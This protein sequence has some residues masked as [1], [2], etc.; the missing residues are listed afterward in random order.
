L[1]AFFC[2][3]SKNGR[4]ILEFFLVETT[5]DPLLSCAT[6]GSPS[7]RPKARAVKG[8]A[9]ASPYASAAAAYSG[10]IKKLS[11]KKGK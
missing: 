11:E 4:P 5:V 3:N 7:Y 2:L 6:G 9:D 10:I 1:F 8:Y